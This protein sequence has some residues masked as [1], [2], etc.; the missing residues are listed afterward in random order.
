[1]PFF[2]V[3]RSAP[4]PRPSPVEAA[5]DAAA[6]CLAVALGCGAAALTFGGLLVP[7]GALLPDAAPASP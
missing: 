7:D 5:L 2:A 4:A 1:M 3:F 6:F